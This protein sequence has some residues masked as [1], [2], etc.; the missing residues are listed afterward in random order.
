MTKKNTNKQFAHYKKWTTDEG[1]TFLAE[2]KEDAI[3]YLENMSHLGKLVTMENLQE[4]TG[5]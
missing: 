4:V 2:S 1:F 5:E 3:K